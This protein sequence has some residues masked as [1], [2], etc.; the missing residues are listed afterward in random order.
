MKAT[1][2]VTDSQ[3]RFSLEAVELSD[4]GRDD[5]VIRTAYSGVSI[6]TEF[7]LIRNKISW[8]PFPLVTGYMA[9]GR[10]EAVGADVRGFKPGDLVFARANGRMTLADGTPLS[11]VSGTHCSHIVS[12]VGG[13]HGIGRL[14]ENASLETASLFV[15]PAVGYHGVDMSGVR[16]GETVVAYGAGLI[17]LGVVAAASLR[18][19]RV[20]AIDVQ[21][22]PLEMARALGADILI[23]AG[24]C[25]PGAELETIVPGGA[26]A[27]FECTGNPALIDRAI[28]LCRPQGKFVWQGNYGAAP[29]SFSFLSAHG[30]Q[31]QTYFPCDDGLMPCRMTVIKQMARG[32]LP[33]EGTISH[34]VRAEEAPAI[35]QRISS[36]E[37]GIIGVTINW[38]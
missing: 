8:G 27:V 31:L 35:F 23:N 33:W 29:I 21:D 17:G 37:Q 32:I 25:D 19:C 1:A 38:N 14:P 18:G 16:M 34:R 3:C 20:V 24:R 13:T 5:V 4:P 36:G 6:G 30:K 26:D 10:V 7:A 28:N 11:S 15:T 9:T 22:S 2:L 12:Q